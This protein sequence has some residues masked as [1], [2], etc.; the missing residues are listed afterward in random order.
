MS[1]L[2]SVGE[3]L[4]RNVKRLNTNVVIVFEEIISWK[5]PSRP[6]G[7]LFP[8]SQGPLPCLTCD[9]FY[10]RTPLTLFLTFSCAFAG[11]YGFFAVTYLS[12]NLRRIMGSED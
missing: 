7:E 5:L 6:R 12:Q 11:G 1:A 2:E 10:F 4:V 8:R 9:N 3:Q